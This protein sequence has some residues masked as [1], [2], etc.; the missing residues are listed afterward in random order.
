LELK[1]NTRLFQAEITS[2]AVRSHNNKTAF[3]VLVIVMNKSGNIEV[4]DPATK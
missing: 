4:D 3:E 2:F 1:K